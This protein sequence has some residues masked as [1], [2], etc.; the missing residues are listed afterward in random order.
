[1]LDEITAL[2][3]QF[4]G[5]ES[6]ADKAQAL[7]KILELA[8]SNTTGCTIERFEDNGIKSALIYNHKKRPQQFK[9]I[10][11]SH[12]DIIPANKQQYLPKIKGKRLYGAGSMDM[13]A[14]AACFIVTF[15]EVVGKIN[16][17]LGLQ[18]VTDE[19][20]G[21]FHGTKHQVESGVRAGFVIASETT[22]FDI[23]N[24]TK[25]V[26]W[27]HISALGKAAHGAYPWKGENAIWKMNQFLNILKK[28]YPLPEQDTWATTLNLSRI[29]T[30]NQ[31]YNKV[32]DNCEVWLDVRYIP[33][34]SDTIVD[35]IKALLP[36]GFS[37]QV[38]AQE[39]AQF[40]DKNNRY[41]KLLQTVGK[42]IIGKELAVRG[43]HGSSDVRHFAHVNNPGIEFG[44][45]GNGIGSANEWIDIP[46]LEKYHRILKEFLLSLN[47][48]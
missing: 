2:A 24:K 17:P 25:G 29:T 30:T 1:M 28:H 10:L 40:V 44:A 33:E 4:I 21:G 26:L 35:T 23:V 43:A 8:M 13:K 46:S 11:N 19:E 15:M 36:K 34:E 31:A 9:V 39:P 48:V 38:I 27:L 20:I 12:L 47:K 6:T 18:L 16:Y 3:K 7:D 5:I 37:M 45:V 22:N 41:I 42:P 32:P 14:N